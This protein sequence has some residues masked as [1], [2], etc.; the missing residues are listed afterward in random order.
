MLLEAVDGNA[1]SLL[2]QAGHALA[3]FDININVSV[4]DKVEKVGCTGR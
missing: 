4:R 2:F 1:S 3:N